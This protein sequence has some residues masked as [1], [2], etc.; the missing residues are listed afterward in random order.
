MPKRLYWRAAFILLF[1]VIFLQLI[2]SVVIMKRHFE[3]V[4]EQ[5]TGT[6]ASQ[7]K[8]IATKVEA[9]EI[10]AAIELSEGLNMKLLPVELDNSI[11]SNSKRFY[12]V[13]GIVVIREL[14]KLKWVQNVDLLDDDYVTVTL[15]LTDMIFQ[16]KFDRARVSASNPHQ[17][18]VNMVVFGAF[19]T[20]IA[21]MYLRNQLRPIT[22]LA[23]AAEAFGRGQTVPYTASGAIEVKAAGNA[24]LEMRNRIERH[25]EQRTMI[26][27]GVSHDLRTPLTRL[28]LG[29]S[30]L[31]S[32]DKE[33]LERDLEEMRLMLDE[34]LTFAKAQDN[35]KS[36]FE[37]LTVSSILDSLKADYQRSNAK[38]HVAN[39]IT[40]GS[41][42]MRPSLIRRAL[43]N[44]I[45]NALRYGTLA[46]LRVT[47][48]NEHIN[49]IVEDDGPG[50]PEEMRPEALKPFSRLDPARNQD[51][52]M[53]VGLGLPIASD[54]AQAHGGSLRL[55]KSDKYGGLRAEFK[56]AAKKQLS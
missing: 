7:I 29:I 37:L 54:I 43:D 25:I 22:R 41:Y 42:L 36:N 28:K 13:S 6:V 44:I 3:G 35:E 47:V 1:P 11:G 26:L 56:I 14:Y 9:A 5:M 21:F 40:T 4:T 39:N 16:L 45:G 48:D 10:D 49:F 12:D 20:L 53:G 52:G 33:P 34:F 27:S 23:T 2:V 46:N 8:L 24:F 17:L 18:I 51:K 19:F 32:D 55:L 50:I 30:L 31:D 15:R 38:L